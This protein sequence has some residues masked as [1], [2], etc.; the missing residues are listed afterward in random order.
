VLGGDDDAV[1]VAGTLPHVRA[2]PLDVAE[3]LLDRRD[4]FLADWGQA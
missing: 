4:E 3:E 1:A 2:Q